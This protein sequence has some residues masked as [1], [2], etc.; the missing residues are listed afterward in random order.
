MAHTKVRTSPKLIED[1]SEKA[2]IYNP[3]TASAVPKRDCHFGLCPKMIK[4]RKGT[5]AT[6][7]PVMKPDLPDEVYSHPYV[8]KA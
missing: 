2:M 3:H 5:K 4:V 7:K 8:C 6:D 1:K